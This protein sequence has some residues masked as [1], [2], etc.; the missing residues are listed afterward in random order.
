MIFPTMLVNHLLDRAERDRGAHCALVAPGTRVSYLELARLRRHCAANLA[1]AGVRRGDRVLLVLENSVEF[2]ACFFGILACGAIAVPLSHRIQQSRLDFIVRDCEPAAIIGAVSASAGPA[3]TA[4][5]AL[6]REPGG[7]PV[8]APGTVD[9]D[10]ALLI[11]TSGSTGQ[12]K[13]VLLSH[14]N[15]LSAARSIQGYLALEESDVI[16]C[17]LPLSFDYGL[18]QILLATQIGATVVLEESLTYPAQVLKVIEENGVTVLPGVPT[19]FGLM[20]RL[21]AFSGTRLRSLRI[22]TNTGARLSTKTIAELRERFPQARLFS[23]YGLTECKRVSYLPPDQLDAR[24]DSVGRGMPNQELWLE[25]DNG[26]RL[27]PGSEGQL[28]VRG[29]HVMLGYWRRPLETRACL[30]IDSQTGERILRTGDVFRTDPEGYLYFVRRRDDIIKSRGQKVSPREVEDAIARLPGVT[31]AVIVGVPD[32][33]HGQIVKAFVV[34]LPEYGYSEQTV[35][36]HCKDCLEPYMVPDEVEL[37][38][39]L[40]QHENG[41]IDRLSLLQ[42]ARRAKA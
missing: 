2:A 21:A 40:P 1:A 29:S 28:I 41:K 36:A 19:L 37:R 33:L 32:E 10:A 9:L 8:P 16:L 5:A 13:G 4:A 23:M 12:P 24:P 17:G 30:R 15:V 14:L 7:V 27:P 11:Y 20:L 35:L 3:S 34:A 31:D 42:N 18:Y 6:L 22:L 38:D 39:R 25:D 26:N